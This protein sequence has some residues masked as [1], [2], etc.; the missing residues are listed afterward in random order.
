ME[1]PQLSQDLLNLKSFDLTP[2]IDPPIQPPTHPWVGVS[3][4]IINLQT[5]LNYL[6]SVNIF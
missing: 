3:L 4:Q 6:G 1:L 2:P 5:E